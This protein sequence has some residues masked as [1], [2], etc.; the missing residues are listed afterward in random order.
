MNRLSKI[1]LTGT[2]VSLLATSSAI[3]AD[4]TGS[5]TSMTVSKSA[6]N[7][8]VFSLSVAPS[9]NGEINC[10]VEGW[11]KVKAGKSDVQ[12]SLLESAFYNNKSIKVTS[13]AD[14]CSL[15]ESMDKAINAQ[16]ITVGLP[17]SEMKSRSEK[18][19]GGFIES[20][21]GPV[22]LPSE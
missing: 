8:V 9:K 20:R 2:M 13:K 21:Q 12:Y 5:V 6:K 4:V 17:R 16:S 22:G 19:I 7:T 1:L 3:A 15:P 14:G 11:F 18:I 10:S